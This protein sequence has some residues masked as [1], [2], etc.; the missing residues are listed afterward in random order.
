MHRPHFGYSGTTHRTWGARPTRRV[1]K[2]VDGANRAVDGRCVQRFVARQAIQTRRRAAGP[3]RKLA[4]GALRA[5]TAGKEQPR[6][7][8]Q[9]AP[10][11]TSRHTRHN[12]QKR[13]LHAPVPAPPRSAIV[14]RGVLRRRQSAV[15]AGF[16]TCLALVRLEKIVPDARKAHARTGRGRDGARDTRFTLGGAGVHV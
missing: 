5:L 11:N 13:K 7:T 6:W 1:G 4:D 16:A 2:R 15:G 8:R 14:A 9:T 10:K 3:R 12:K